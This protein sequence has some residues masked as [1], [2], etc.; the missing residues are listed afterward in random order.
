[1]PVGS[2]EVTVAFRLISERAVSRA[3]W[4]KSTAVI[5]FIDVILVPMNNKFI[6]F[7]CGLFNDAVSSSG[8]IG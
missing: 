5:L 4:S 6:L 1:V 7:I 2:R 3:Q 8:Y